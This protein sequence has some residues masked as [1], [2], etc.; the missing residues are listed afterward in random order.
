M[1][2]TVLLESRI[3]HGNQC[4]AGLLRVESE[5][6]SMRPT[7]PRISDLLRRNA[8]ALNASRARVAMAEA[9][10]RQISN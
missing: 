8:E 1:T 4:I 2:R 7:D 5:L 6:R 3:K 9:E 10:L